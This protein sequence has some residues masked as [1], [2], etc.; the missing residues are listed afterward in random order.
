MAYVEWHDTLPD[1][2][3]T[4]KLA[5]RL[6]VSLATAVG[7]LGCLFAWVIRYRPGGEVEIDSVPMACKWRGEPKRLIESLIETGWAHKRAQVLAIHDWSEY[8]RGY[9]RSQNERERLRNKRSTVAQHSANRCA[10]VGVSGTEQNRAEQSGAERAAAAGGLAPPSSEKSPGATS[11]EEVI[12]LL[13]QKADQAKIAAKPDTLRRYVEAWVEKV[14]AQEVERVLATADARGCSVVEL[15]DRF[16]RKNG[17]PEPKFTP[18]VEILR[19]A[20]AEDRAKKLAQDLER[21][22]GGEA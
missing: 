18:A 17:K 16:F 22:I 2:P 15:D 21:K 4:I 8:T 10:T 20:L 11:R 19:R 13:L 5:R 14:G 9:R 7:H 3:K 1:H 12:R 6:K